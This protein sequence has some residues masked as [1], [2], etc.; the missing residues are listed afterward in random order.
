MKIYTHDYSIPA[1]VESKIF[2]AIEELNNDGVE[3][4][5]AR[6]KL[7]SALCD[8]RDY[9][10]KDNEVIDRDVQGYIRLQDTFDEDQLVFIRDEFAC[11][12]P[13]GL[14]PRC[15]R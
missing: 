4:K 5:K 8:I 9:L 7:I 14:C 11:I 6:E 13:E 15:C 1:K 12:T 2:K 3:C 10:A